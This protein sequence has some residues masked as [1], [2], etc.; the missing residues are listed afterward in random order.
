MLGVIGR[1]LNAYAD[2]FASITLL[3]GRLL[4]GEGLC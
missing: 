4:E 3:I 2:K 1:M